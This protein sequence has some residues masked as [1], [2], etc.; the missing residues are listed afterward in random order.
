MQLIIRCEKLNCDNV[1]II[2][3]FQFSFS[4]KIKTFCSFCRAIFSKYFWATEAGWSRLS[5][6]TCSD[7]KNC[8]GL[9]MYELH[10]HKFK[11]KCQVAGSKNC[12][13]PDILLQFWD[14]EIANW[15]LVAEFITS[16]VPIIHWHKG[17]LKWFQCKSRRL[18]PTAFCA[19]WFILNMLLRNLK[20]P[21]EEKTKLLYTIYKCY[22]PQ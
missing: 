5:A 15:V 1:L 19:L 16:V 2:T 11:T 22:M 20:E 18:K 17:S 14:L 21:I 10:M 13:L 12:Q 7:S 4:M 8:L 6:F 9:H 3:F